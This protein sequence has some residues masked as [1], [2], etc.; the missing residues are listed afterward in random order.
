LGSLGMPGYLLRLLRR[1]TTVTES[2]GRLKAAESTSLG[3]GASVLTRISHRSDMHAGTC[4]ST[5][6]TCGDEGSRRLIMLG[7]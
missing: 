6:T 5:F 2:N 1:Y 4:L 7:A 3:L